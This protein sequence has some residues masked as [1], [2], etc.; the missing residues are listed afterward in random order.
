MR[1]II[2]EDEPAAAT[3]LKA[4][5]EAF[6]GAEV[7]AIAESIHDALELL[8]S[9]TRFDLIFADIRLS[10]GSS[11]RIFDELEAP[12]PVVFAT[13]YD[14]HAIEA[15]EK[16]AIDYILKPIDPG[17]VAQALEKYQRLGAYFL[18]QRSANIS[19]ARVLARK[20]TAFVAVAVEKIAWFTT[21]HKLTLLVDRDG[22]RLAVD[23][24][25]SELEDRLDA[26][27]FFRVNRQY[28]VQVDAIVKFESA[29]KGRLAVTLEPPANDEVFVSQENAAAFRAWIAG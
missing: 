12:C 20:G 10:D 22:K 3:Q 14:V 18:H 15:M 29:G 13:A 2:F 4:A 25:L 26:K 9:G 6:P 17:R 1:V 23:E 11:F 5:I 8:R 16:N 24:G 28:L 19:P 7:V 27:R 21:E